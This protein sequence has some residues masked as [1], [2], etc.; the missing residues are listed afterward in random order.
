MFPSFQ[1]ISRVKQF[2]H[3]NNLLLLSVIIL[4][5]LGSFY[6]YVGGLVRE[7]R[8]TRQREEAE[9]AEFQKQQLHE[10]A[11]LAKTVEQTS[12]QVEKDRLVREKEHDALVE[13]LAEIERRLLEE[14][15]RRG[16]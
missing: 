13:R 16:S 11:E 5:V 15:K 3:R 12:A 4:T 8:V 14:L 6:M 9:I 2:I 1:T 7:G 10:I